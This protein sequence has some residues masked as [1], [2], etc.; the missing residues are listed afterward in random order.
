M[1]LNAV[2]SEAKHFGAT[3]VVDYCLGA[4]LPPNGRPSLQKCLDHY[5]PHLLTELGLDTF[6]Q[7]DKHG[8][9]FVHAGIVKTVAGLPQSGLFPQLRLVSHLSS[10]GHY[11]TSTPMPFKHV[12]RDIAFALAVDDFGVKCDHLSDYQHLVDSL[13]ASCNVTVEL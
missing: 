3:D 8:K 5:P 1:M 11:E 7:T 13:Q 2:V 12:A 6:V 10:C 4:D 9:L